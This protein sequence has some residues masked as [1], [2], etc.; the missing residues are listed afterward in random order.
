[1]VW[2]IRVVA[3]ATLALGLL[4]YSRRLGN[5]VDYTWNLVHLL[6]GLA[7]A[8]LAFWLLTGRVGRPERAMLR[9]VAAVA[10]GLTL[11][12]GLLMLIGLLEKSA[13]VV[14]VHMLLGLATIA[15]VE[16]GMS[17]RSRAS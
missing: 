14:G 12:V 1:M 17:R 4:L 8:T 5:T 7:L 6:F 2:V 15:L 16:M 9:R 13:A 11:L 3:L 10:G